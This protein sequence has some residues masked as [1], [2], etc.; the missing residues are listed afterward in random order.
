MTRTEGR[1]LSPSPRR[2]VFVSMRFNCANHSLW[3]ALVLNLSRSNR[4]D[5]VC[6]TSSGVYRPLPPRRR[7]RRCLPSDDTPPLVHGAPLP[8]YPYRKYSAIILVTC[9][10]R[11][12]QQ[13]YCQALFGWDWMGLGTRVV[14]GAFLPSLRLGRDQI[15]EDKRGPVR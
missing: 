15:R 11:S 14:L 2:L 7:L 13:S 5:V 3:R 10:A 4:T 9:T 8:K 6:L 1:R 12:V